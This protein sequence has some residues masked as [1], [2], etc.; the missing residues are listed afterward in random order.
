MVNYIELINAIDKSDSTEKVNEILNEGGKNL[1]EN[2]SSIK[3][4]I[5]R[6]IR[7]NCSKILNRLF[8]FIVDDITIFDQAYNDAL[9]LAKQFKQN[10]FLTLLADKDKFKAQVQQSKK[11][12]AVSSPQE[13]EELQEVNNSNFTSQ[14]PQPLP[15]I[16]VK[17]EETK[18]LFTLNGYQGEETSDDT[19]T[20]VT[21][22][23][24]QEEATYPDDD[25]READAI[26]E[27]CLIND[28]SEEAIRL[29]EIFNILCVELDNND[30]VA[31]AQI[32]SINEQLNSMGE[33]NRLL[34]QDAVNVAKLQ[35]TSFCSE[36]IDNINTS[37][38]QN[39][40]P[41]LIIDKDNL[42][43][44]KIK[45]NELFTNLTAGVVEVNNS[46]SNNKS[47]QTNE[48]NNGNSTITI[49]APVKQQNN[50]VTT[51]GN[52]ASLPNNYIE[53]LELAI[54]LAQSLEQQNNNVTTQGNNASSQVKQPR[55]NLSP[56]T[57][58][59]PTVPQS[60][61]SAENNKD[62]KSHSKSKNCNITPLIYTTGAFAGSGA[63][64][65]AISSLA[66]NIMLIST[67][68]PFT[69]GIA[70]IILACIIAVSLTVCANRDKLFSSK[71]EHQRESFSQEQTRTP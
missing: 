24:Y 1:S 28:N 55:S 17:S 2:Y 46:F 71:V 58:I 60:S 30:D 23:S 13:I 66:F 25:V 64:G 47:C 31:L 8:E 39:Q 54:A 44:A 63:V 36:F 15:S 11:E 65:T 3:E 19:L 4:A 45:V 59:Q 52:K 27:E 18:P 10:D 16:S 67:I 6:S 7:N 34:N 61:R 56:T 40:N 26:K 53:D 42:E 29:F 48:H 9:A 51:Q 32:F 68:S 49:A 14:E 69:M 43:E 70:C 12:R 22:N 50:N 33:V 37:L 62:E 57:G 35:I 21:S 41:H 5:K 38:S 20:Q